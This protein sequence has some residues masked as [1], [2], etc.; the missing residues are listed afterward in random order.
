MACFICKENGHWSR[1]C[2]QAVCKFC[3]EKGHSAAVCELQKTYKKDVKPVMIEEP[4]TRSRSRKVVGKSWDD[5]LYENHMCP[6]ACMKTDVD[7]FVKAKFSKNGAIDTDEL[8]DSMFEDVMVMT[9]DEGHM[10]VYG[11]LVAKYCE[12]SNAHVKAFL[13]KVYQE[14]DGKFLKQVFSVITVIKNGSVH[15]RKYTGYSC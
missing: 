15:F 14:K 9:E 10:R 8:A 11:Y 4:V 2:P 7:A 5:I 13:R 3:G 6:A 12:V 1:D